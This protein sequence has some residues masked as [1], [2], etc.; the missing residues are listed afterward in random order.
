MEAEPAPFSGLTGSAAD[1]EAQ[2]GPHTYPV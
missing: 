2:L 1:T